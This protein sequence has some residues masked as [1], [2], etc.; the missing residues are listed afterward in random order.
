MA[1]SDRDSGAGARA[2]RKRFTD[3]AFENAQADVRAIDDFHEPD[4]HLRGN[5]G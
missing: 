1:S 2:A 5:R 4:V 3:A